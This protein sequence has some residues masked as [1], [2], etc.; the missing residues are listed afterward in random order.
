MAGFLF[1]WSFHTTLEL[2]MLISI[3]IMIHRLPFAMV[4]GGNDG[5]GGQHRISSS[6]GE[7]K[8]NVF[9]FEGCA[10]RW[11]RIVMMTSF[12]FDQLIEL[13]RLKIINCWSFRRMGINPTK[14]VASAPC[15]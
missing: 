3:T 5:L 4:V 1:A 15:T 9:T 14:E 11:A 7:G 2:W 6:V 8:V 13:R 12:G 10:S